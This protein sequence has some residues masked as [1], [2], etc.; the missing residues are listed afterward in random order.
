MAC[1]YCGR[2]HISSDDAGVCS[3]NC[4]KLVCIQAISSRPQDYH[5]DQCNC[6]CAELVCIYEMHRHAK[7]RHGSTVENCFPDSAAQAG[8]GAAWALE[9]SGNVRVDQ[10]TPDGAEIRRA[11]YRFV[12]IERPPAGD[13]PLP[14]AT[15][16]SPDYYDRPLLRTGEPWLPTA[17][18]LVPYVFGALVR[19]WPRVKNLDFKYGLGRRVNERMDALVAAS[20]RHRDLVANPAPVLQAWFDFSPRLAL[21]FITQGRDKGLRDRVQIV[22]GNH[23]VSR[24]LKAGTAWKD[25]PAT[26][27]D[28][29]M[30]HGAPFAR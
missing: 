4:N 12:T 22:P 26:L 17:A 13:V 18:A 15:A 21:L 14:F 19:C 27:A 11:I 8:L 16:D 9:Q 1:F 29:N 3:E 23:D 6:G 10:P 2:R 5:G 20:A 30:Q 25:A 28:V 7:N 24:V